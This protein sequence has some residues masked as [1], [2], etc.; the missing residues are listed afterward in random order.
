MKH[1]FVQPDKALEQFL[2]KTYNEDEDAELLLEL[3]MFADLNNKKVKEAA[4]RTGFFA[5][6]DI[7]YSRVKAMKD[8]RAEGSDIDSICRY[9]L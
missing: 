3:A 5:R 8:G 4:M 7:K 1:T 9:H 2:G 6:A